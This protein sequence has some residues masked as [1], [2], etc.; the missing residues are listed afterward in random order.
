[1]NWKVK[2]WARLAIE[3]TLCALN[4]ESL[5]EKV[6]NITGRATRIDEAFI[7]QRVDRKLE[8]IDAILQAQEVRKVHEQG[9]GWHG[10][11]LIVFYLMGLPVFTTDVRDLLSV[12]LM[13]N[14]VRV[15]VGNIDKYAR[16]RGP[17]NKLEELNSRSDMSRAD[18]LR[19]INVDYVVDDNFDFS[20]VS[21]ID[22]LYSDS[23]LQRMKIADLRRYVSNSR[24]AASPR[25]SHYHRV[26]CKDFFS[27][28][29]EDFIPPLYYL[30]VKDS[31]WEFVTCKRLNY[32]NR[33]RM[34]EFL[35]LFDSAGYV[36]G[37]FDAE[38]IEGC[39]DFVN[40][41]KDSIGTSN[42]YS[43]RDIAITSFTLWAN[44]LV[45]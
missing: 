36:P 8:E 23:V 25:A 38:T 34:P 27:I 44:P 3:K 29:K 31:F 41:N 5:Q 20:R 9:T 19:G 45:S 33:L 43:P 7:L 21:D 17:I 24:C 18:F 10:I 1:V 11:D 37:V 15:L 22:L 39:L 42:I 13:K 14:T 28:G 40:E 6:K 12:S 26:D 2:Y 16:F 32:Q 35:S 30:T 4:M